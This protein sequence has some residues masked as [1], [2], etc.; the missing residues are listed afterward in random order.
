MH[1]DPLRT[2]PLGMIR[3]S[4]EFLEAAKIVDE[5]IGDQPGFEIVAPIPA[6]YLVGHSIELSLKSFL[7]HN[8][9]SLRELRSSHYGHNLHACLRKGK[10]L[11]LLNH[12]QFTAQENSAFE[13]LN[14]LYSTKQLEYIVTGEKRFPIFGHIELFAVKLCNAVSDIVGFEKQFT[15]YIYTKP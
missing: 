14:A 12:V 2:T 10:E 9:I 11:G 6:Q 4:H 15:G 13:T 3:Y 1:D 8:G 7:L 5:N